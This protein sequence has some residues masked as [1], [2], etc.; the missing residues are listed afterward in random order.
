M[1]D[2]VRPHQAAAAAADADAPP[3]HLQRPQGYIPLLQR[4]T[5][6]AVAARWDELGEGARAKVLAKHPTNAPRLAAALRASE[7]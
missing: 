5:G 3:T 1:L 6:K 2:C 4:V 7:E